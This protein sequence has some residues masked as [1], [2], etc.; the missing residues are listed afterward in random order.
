MRG[1]CDNT[2]TWEHKGFVCETY[3]QRN[4]IDCQNVH[5]NTYEDPSKSSVMHLI[6]GNQ[7]CLSIY[8]WFIKIYEGMSHEQ[9]CSF[10]NHEIIYLNAADL[11]TLMPVWDKFNFCNHFDI[12]KL[13]RQRFICKRE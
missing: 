7:Q 1:T 6:S 3:A 8:I 9:K 5:S 11:S 13:T 2:V 10:I 12:I 4:H